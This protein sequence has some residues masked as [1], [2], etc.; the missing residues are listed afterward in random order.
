MSNDKHKVLN[1][2]IANSTLQIFG[3]K[4]IKDMFNYIQ[5]MFTTFIKGPKK[6]SEQTFEEAIEQYQLTEEQL[7]KKSDGLLKQSILFVVIGLGFFIFSLFRLYGGFFMQGTLL[8]FIAILLLANAFKSHFWYFQIKN[9]K[10][11]CTFQE[12][13]NGKV[14]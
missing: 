6:G 4:Y 1:S 2:K 5:G 10:L 14:K 7:H 12:W 13:L 8:I 9:R 3:W 11:G